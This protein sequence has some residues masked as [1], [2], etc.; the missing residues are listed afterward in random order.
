MQGLAVVHSVMLFSVHR[1]V[2]VS[3]T[4][5]CI[6]FVGVRISLVFS[7]LGFQAL[8]VLALHPGAILET[9]QM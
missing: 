4:C 3:N 1:Y 5:S 7:D 9:Y 2:S 6:D 8:F